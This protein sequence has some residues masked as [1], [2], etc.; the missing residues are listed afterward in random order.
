MDHRVNQLLKR[1][2]LGTNA[3]NQGHKIADFVYIQITGFVYI[4]WRNVQTCF[5]MLIEINEIKGGFGE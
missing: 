4:L 5:S 3:N 2:T 1:T